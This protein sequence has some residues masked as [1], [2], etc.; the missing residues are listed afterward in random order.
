MLFMILSVG[1]GGALG[2]I[3]RYLVG[4][5]VSHYIPHHSWIATLSV[6]ITGCFIMGAIAA[7]LFETATLSP[8]VKSFVMIGFLGALTTFS[9]FA[10][11]FHMLSEKQGFMASAGY[12]MA[13]V[14]LSLSMFFASFW[15][16]RSTGEQQ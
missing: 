9:S 3:A 11:D 13:S 15:L 16:F 10:L 1:A 7:M 2:A 5:M 6:N 14:G 12:L 8:A 4:V